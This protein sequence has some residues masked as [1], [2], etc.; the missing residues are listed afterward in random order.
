[1]LVFVFKKTEVNGDPQMALNTK[2][3]D[4]EK[5]ARVDFNKR[6]NIK[7]HTDASAKVLQ[8]LGEMRSS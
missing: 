4:V 1:M 2:K 7:N 8:L 5:R 6:K 3:Y